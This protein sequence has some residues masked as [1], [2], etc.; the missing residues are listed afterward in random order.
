M[1]ALPGFMLATLVSVSIAA[2][3]ATAGGS[4]DSPGHPASTRA[5][6]EA[7]FRG[8]EDD[9]DPPG[10]YTGNRN[11][12]DDDYDNDGNEN[13]SYY[14]SDDEAMRTFGHAADA[15]EGRLLAGLVE[16]YRAATVAGDGAS[17]CSMLS[18]SLAI[19]VVVDYGRPPG[20]AYLRGGTCQAVLGLLF[21][22]SRNLLKG[23]IEVT[24]VRVSGAQ[25]LVL[26]GSQTQPAGS[27]PLR[28][29]HGAWRIDAM[30]PG[31]LT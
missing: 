5:S 26:F 24:A 11:D 15:S 12:K 22:H 2:C 10:S 14:D 13:P 28:R 19:S 7:H 25:A 18:S 4:R 3:G 23:S 31:G 1:R 16:R 9:D 6:A 30:L 20:P 29:E 17:A 8:D 21:E 27:M